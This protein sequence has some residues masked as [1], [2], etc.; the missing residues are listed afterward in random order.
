M[1]ALELMK[2]RCSIRK[3]DSRPV[4]EE[5][6]QY[7]LEA[8]RMAPSAVNY[9]PWYF[10]VITGE[11]G[12]K[13]VV[14]CYQREWIKSAP[15]VIAVCGDHSQSWKR[16]IDGKDHL[17]IDVGIVTEHIC[18]AATEQELATCIICHFD[19]A[20]FSQQ[21]NLPESVEPLVLIPIAYPADPDIFAQ[22]PK[23]R[24]LLEEIVKRECF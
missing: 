22:T 14:E 13:K 24:K 1:N 4:E 10:L 6:L 12:R 17:D 3:Y 15:V 11:E 20:L 7:I 18:L 21:F 23:R 9:Q 5:K 19:A 2:K 8:A 16:P